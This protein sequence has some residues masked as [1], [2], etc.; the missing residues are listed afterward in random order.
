MSI[1]CS[2]LYNQVLNIKVFRFRQTSIVVGEL[3][4]RTTGAQ[5]H[6]SSSQGEHI[7]SDPEF[8]YATLFASSRASRRW[9]CGRRQGGHPRKETSI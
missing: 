1:L 7:V 2:L 8:F 9:T 6:S 4:C 5:K 3:N